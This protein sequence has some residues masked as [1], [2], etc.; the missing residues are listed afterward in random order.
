MC[1]AWTSYKQ[2]AIRGC[3][4]LLPP[5]ILGAVRMRQSHQRPAG[6][7]I[8]KPVQRQG[9]SLHPCSLLTQFLPWS[10]THRGSRKLRA[11]V[12]HSALSCCQRERV[13]PLKWH[14]LGIARSFS[15]ANNCYKQALFKNTFHSMLIGE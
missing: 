12:R 11:A 7:Q 8:K 1:L 13:F 10:C 3:Q 9:S 6:L 5:L 14:L 2:E 4:F 15:S